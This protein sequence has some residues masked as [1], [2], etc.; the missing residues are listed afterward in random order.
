MSGL[1][2]AS[3]YMYYDTIDTHTASKTDDPNNDSNVKN[4]ASETN[5]DKGDNMNMKSE[6]SETNSPEKDNFLAWRRINKYN[7]PQDYRHSLP[8][9]SVKYHLDYTLNRFTR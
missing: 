2:A 9:L 4:E 3:S 1:S 5:P 6:N 7:T 8:P